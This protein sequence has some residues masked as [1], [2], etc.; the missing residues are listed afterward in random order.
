MFRDEVLEKLLS[1]KSIQGQR[2]IRKGDPDV[3]LNADSARVRSRQLG[4][5]GIRRYATLDGGE[6]WMPCTNESDYRRYMGVGPQAQRDR[7]KRERQF[8]QR[9]VNAKPKNSRISS[10]IQKTKQINTKSAK[11]SEDNRF[12]VAKVRSHNQEIKLSGKPETYMAT[13]SMLQTIWDKEKKNGSKEAMKR[14]NIFLAVLSGARPKNLK[15]I[16]DMALLPDGHPR[17]SDL[18]SSRYSFVQPKNE[19]P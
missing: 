6:A 11:P 8:I 3:Y 18:R 2:K 19:R 5:I 10:N 9:V 12:L 14:V 17:K 1:E 13:P 16:S 4:C 7:A 15:Y